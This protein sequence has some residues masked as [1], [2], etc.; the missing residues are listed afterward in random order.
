[1]PEL[2]EVETVRRSIAPHLAGR[3]IV[4]AEFRCVRLLRGGDPDDMSARLAGRRITAVRRRGKFLLIE[5]EGGL[6]LL[7]HL[8]MTGRLLVGHEP[9]PYTH[10][11]LTLDRGVLIYDDPRQ[12][13]CLELHDAI[14]ARVARLGPEPLE[15]SPEAFVAALRKR[16]T[17]LKALLLDQTFLR[18][19]GNIYADE[20]L[21]RARI[22]PFAIAARLS[23]E[24]ALRLHAA[25]VEVLTE[26]IAA[27]G[28]SI[29]DYV[30]ADGRRGFFQTSH[31]VYQRT[32]EPC[33]VCG[34]PIR[35]TL[36]A[37]RGTHYCP[38]CQ[39]A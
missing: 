21:F 22:H 36:V 35:R 3:R 24:R 25:I 17:R 38:R 16:R 15:I 13:G 6:I 34:T 5:C 26:A 20:S 9:G 37:Q 30:D 1:V 29:S 8:G 33:V 14:P 39:R 2:P 31:R 10:A 18:G 28:S 23:R 27:G 12:F 7:V 19:I 32:G 11:I 4:S